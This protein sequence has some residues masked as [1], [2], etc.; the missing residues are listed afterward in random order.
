MPIRFGLIGCGKITERLA[1][2][3]LARCRGARVSALIDVDR[4]AAQRLADR[5][6]ISRRLIW[7]DWRRMLREADVDAVAVNVPN[8]LHEEL[9]V[10]ALEAK[11]HVIVE[12][13][14]ATSLPE[15]DAMIRAARRA[16]RFLM[17]EQSQRFDPAHEVAHELLRRGRLGRIT[18]LRGRIGHAGPRYWSGKR[19]SW[20]TERQRSGGGALM[21]IGTHIVDLLRWMSGKEVRRICCGA[22]TLDRRLSVE[23]HASALLEFTDRTLGSFE[24]CWATRPYEVST[25]AYG[26]RGTLR[27]AFGAA[28]PV[29]M[30][31]CR[32]RGDPN[33]EESGDRFPAVP[34]ASRLGGAYPYFA[35]CI[36]TGTQPF[37]SGE[38]GRATLEVILAA[39]E[40][41]RTGSWVTLPLRA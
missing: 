22:K 32:R 39:Y 10:A 28:R 1:L 12:K 31:L 30:Q 9:A 15:A 2:P 34:P 20:F 36:A 33:K 26:T 4:R 5:F 41:A 11:K 38:E 17:V 7:T 35:R 23:D 37:I 18:Q 27:T 40:S 16:R 25:Q 24:V 29:V 14:I 6:G 19:S 21:D 3:Q 8:A 13:P